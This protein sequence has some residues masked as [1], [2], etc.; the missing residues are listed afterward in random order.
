MQSFGR[1]DDPIRKIL[2]REF[3][4]FRILAA[5]KNAKEIADILNISQKTVVNFQVI[6]KQKLGI[7]SPV[8]L[9]RLALRLGLI[10]G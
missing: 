3:E 10:E 2:G 4:V 6:F 1:E 5:G 8:E 7:S 9:V